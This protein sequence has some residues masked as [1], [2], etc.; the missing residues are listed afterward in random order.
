MM[1][2]QLKN[3]YSDPNYIKKFILSIDKTKM[4]LSDAEDKEQDIVDGPVMDSTDFGKKDK[5][6]SKFDKKKL[7]GFT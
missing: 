5:D 7:E 6:R 2:K 1:V 4:R 3:R